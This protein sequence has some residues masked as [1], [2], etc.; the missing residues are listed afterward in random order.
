M[1]FKAKLAS[2]Q[3]SLLYHLTGC[4]ARLNHTKET[5]S[6]PGLLMG[7][8]VLRLDESKVRLTTK[9]QNDADGVSVFCELSTTDGIFL[10]HRIQSAA[11][12]NAIAMEV[13]LSQIRQALQSILANQES[14]FSKHG[15][16]NSTTD[17]GW[18]QYSTTILKLAKRERIPCLCLDACTRDGV[19]AVH[20]SIPVRIMRVE[21]ANHHLPPRVDR[22]DVQLQMTPDRPLKILAERL[23]T[24]CPQVYLEASAAGELTL[25][26]EKEGSTVRAFFGKL[27]PMQEECR[28]GARETALLKVD[29]KKLVC[30]LQWQ[31]S[32]M[33]P[34]VSNALLCFIEN[35]ML[36]VHV[37]FNPNTL[38]FLTYYVPVN[39]LSQ[40]EMEDY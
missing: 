4:I 15:N 3:V 14:Q 13:D 22:P 25:R 17:V 37:T 1:R 2:E 7:G 29:T 26:T 23:K 16:N 35:Q 24:A 6:G 12:N 39:F 31:Q 5:A 32:G 9:G 21:D 27:V 34:N 11:P 40:E 38:G 19:V 10:E 8:T 30:C 20:H 36:V 18:V 33:I 28:E